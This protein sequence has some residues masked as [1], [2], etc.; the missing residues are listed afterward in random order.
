MGKEV[1][2]VD[3]QPSYKMSSRAKFLLSMLIVL[4][5][6][7]TLV[8]AGYLISNANVFYNQN[9]K[10]IFF[11]MTMGEVFGISVLWLIYGTAIWAVFKEL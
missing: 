2:K 8:F 3:Y 4:V 9:L 10:V 7:V 1:P 6:A 11:G 5:L